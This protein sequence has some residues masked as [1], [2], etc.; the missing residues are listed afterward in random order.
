MWPCLD[1]ILDAPARDV[2][3]CHCMFGS[4]YQKP[5]RLRVY[6]TLDLRPL[7]KICVRRCGALACG[8]KAH[9]P[10]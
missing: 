7:G 10:P 2:F 3:L 5:T 8:R 4:C 6:G 9:C 1:D